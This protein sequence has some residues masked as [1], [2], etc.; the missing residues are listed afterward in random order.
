M[1][2]EILT[3]SLLLPTIAHIAVM[4]SDMR[5]FEFG[6]LTQ[7]DERQVP[8]AGGTSAGRGLP[9]HLVRLCDPA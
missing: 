5:C 7:A 6:A 9:G 8:G 3:S 2:H 1:L 4:V